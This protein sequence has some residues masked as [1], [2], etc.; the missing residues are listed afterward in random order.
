MMNPVEVSLDDTLSGKRFDSP[1]FSANTKVAKFC[2]TTIN[3]NVK[4]EPID[5]LSQG[6]YEVMLNDATAP[7][8]VAMQAFLG[9]PGKLM[10]DGVTL[11]TTRKGFID[12]QEQ[13]DLYKM[14]LESIVLGDF[15]ETVETE[16][17]KYFI[18]V[19]DSHH[20][21]LPEAC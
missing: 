20:R 17:S 8:Y 21:E 5:R 2:K 3:T 11:E 18:E 10:G 19:A 9:Y 16:V 6:L 1:E 4:D 15:E 14:H 12:F 7:T 13:C